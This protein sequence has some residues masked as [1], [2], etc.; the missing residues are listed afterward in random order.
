MATEAYAGY[1][2]GFGGYYRVSD[3]TGPYT[4][5]TAGV[6]RLIGLPGSPALPAGF[7]LFVPAAGVEVSVIA[8]MASN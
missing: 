5:D 7:N 8:V 1:R 2:R 3:D 4:I 6:A